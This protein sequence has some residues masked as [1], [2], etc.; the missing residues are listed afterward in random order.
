MELKEGD[1]GDDVWALSL[2]F[3][4]KELSDS[5]SVRALKLAI[6]YRN[7]HPFSTGDTNIDEAVETFLANFKTK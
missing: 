6:A 1:L 2:A 5:N 4:P 7:Q 3:S